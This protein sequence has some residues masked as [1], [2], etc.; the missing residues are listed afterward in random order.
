[1]DGLR[2]SHTPPAP[3]PDVEIR[4]LKAGQKLTFTVYSESFWGCWVHWNGQTT[5]PCFEDVKKCAGHLRQLPLRWKGYLHGFEHERSKDIFLE[6]TALA[7]QQLL[8]FFEHAA[9]LRGKRF[10]V[11]RMQ[12]DKSRLRVQPLATVEHA[13]SLPDAKSPL[14]VLAKLWVLPINKHLNGGHTKLPNDQ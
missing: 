2:L 10:S 3:G 7:A 6:F 12:G 11:S 14:S 1:M 4:R 5:E 9:L 8:S 13:N